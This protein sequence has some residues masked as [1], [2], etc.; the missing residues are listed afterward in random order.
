MAS[1]TSKPI[2]FRGGC[3]IARMVDGTAHADDLLHLFH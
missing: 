2:E 1:L 3:H